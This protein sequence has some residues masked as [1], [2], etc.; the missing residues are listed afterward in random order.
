MNQRILIGAAGAAIVALLLVIFYVLGNDRS[1]AGD[2]DIV[3]SPTDPSQ[4]VPGR[5]GSQDDSGGAVFIP[6]NDPVERLERYR[7]WAVFPPFSR[8]LHAGQVDLLEP[9]SAARPAVGVIKTP[10]RDCVTGFNGGRECAASAEISDLQCEMTPAS[11]ISVGRGDFQITVSCVDPRGERLALE[12]LQAKVYRKLFRKTYGSLPPVS[13]ND[14]GESGDAAAGD[15]VYTIV[16][17]PTA[18]DW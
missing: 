10:A 3:A 1:G 18:Q 7:K 11:S 9:Y 14:Q 13:I 16:V 15:R 17:R 8:P 12:G 5:P 2:Q 4:D 6:P